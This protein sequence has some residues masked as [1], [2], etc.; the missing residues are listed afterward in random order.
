MARG[1]D[2]FPISAV[3]GEGIPALVW[4]LAQMVEEAR[5]AV[6]VDVPEERTVYTFD[7]QRERGF[8]VLREEGGFH[9]TGDRV[10]KLLRAVDIANPQAL[11]YVQ[12]RLKRMGV[13]DELLRQGAREGDAVIIGDYVFD[14]LPE[15]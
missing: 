6:G 14:F 3:S 5:S 13:E 2:F 8:R 7:P 12:G 10:E 15:R 4:R 1:W 9:V 11:A